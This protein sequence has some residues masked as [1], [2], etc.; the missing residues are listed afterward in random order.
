MYI[1]NS[2]FNVP[3]GK[4]EEVIRIYSGRS[5][6]VDRAAGFLSFQLLQNQKRP[7]ELV[8]HMEWDTR[9]HYLAWA[10]SDEFKEIHE[11]EK[12]YPDQELAGII[13]KVAQ[14]KVVAD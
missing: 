1:V 11:L 10:R 6:R 2:T 9:E 4:A 5:K 14:Y 7:G 12:K 13:P 8:V 3:A